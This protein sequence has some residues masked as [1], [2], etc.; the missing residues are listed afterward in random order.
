MN[1]LSLQSEVV[2]GH[3]GNGAARLALW[4]LGHEVWAVPT[5]ILSSHAGYPVV[6][7]EPVAADLMRRLVGGVA[8]NGWLAQCGAVLSGYFGNAAQAEVVADAVVRAK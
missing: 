4:R 6:Q 1:V 5:V 8:A 2:Y 3:V 7:G